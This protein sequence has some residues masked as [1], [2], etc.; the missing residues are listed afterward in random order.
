MHSV[1]VAGDLPFPPRRRRQLAPP[2]L[3][4]TH[5]TFATT[6]R[7]AQVMSAVHDV[8]LELPECGHLEIRIGHRQLFEQALQYVGECEVL[9]YVG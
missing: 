2:S 6:P 9:L 1:Q 5:P 7:A 3:P 8:L 4:P